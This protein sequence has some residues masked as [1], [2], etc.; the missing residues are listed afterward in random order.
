MVNTDQAFP[1]QA[2][3]AYVGQWLAGCPKSYKSLFL[4]LETTVQIPFSRCDDSIASGS[5]SLPLLP[6]PHLPLPPPFPFP[7]SP[8]T[9][10][11]TLTCSW[12]LISSSRSSH[13]NSTPENG[14]VSVSE[15]MS[16]GAYVMVCDERGTLITK[17]QNRSEGEN[18]EADRPAL[19]EGE[20]PGRPT[21]DPVIVARTQGLQE[22][23]PRTGR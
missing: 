1:S 9:F 16:S 12:S 17:A 21:E 22:Q 7:S 11:H 15:D 14:S 5:P 19:K 18:K 20:G 13:S 23:P 3:L 2:R 4:G 6:S 8:P 10:A